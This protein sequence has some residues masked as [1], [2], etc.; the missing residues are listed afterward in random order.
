[1]KT[2]AITALAIATLLITVPPLPAS[3]VTNGTAEASAALARSLGARRAVFYLEKGRV[4]S[5][6]WLLS[7]KG[8]PK[9]KA[10]DAIRR[11]TGIK[12]AFAKREAMGGNE[13]LTPRAG[14]TAVLAEGATTE[15]FSVGHANYEYKPKGHQIMVYMPAFGLIRQAPTPENVA[16][17]KPGLDS[18]TVAAILGPWDAPVEEEHGVAITPMTWNR[19]GKPAVRVHFVNEL[20]VKV[21]K[22]QG[23]AAR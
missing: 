23:A 18:D 10:H 14:I 15:A 11:I 7:G 22:L 3:A 12:G 13:W 1:M 16:L 5:E 2:S 19:N 9:Q 6:D 17:I 4:I 8:W 20:V 21:E